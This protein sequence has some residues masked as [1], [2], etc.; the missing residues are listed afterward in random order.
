MATTRAIR[1][2]QTVATG[3]NISSSS[4]SQTSGEGVDFDS[5]RAL[6]LSNTAPK[7]EILSST[8]ADQTGLAANG[9][10]PAT[11]NSLRFKF[12]RLTQNAQTISGGV[13][14]SVT[15]PVFSFTSAIGGGTTQTQNNQ[16]GTAQTQGLNDHFITGSDAS[17][18]G[19]GTGRNDLQDMV[20]KFQ[21]NTSN[22]NSNGLHQATFSMQNH[23]PTLTAT[24]EKTWEGD[25]IVINASDSSHTLPPF[26]SA[27][28]FA[29]AGTK[30]IGI[31]A[32][33]LSSAFTVSE[34]SECFAFA[35]ASVTT[36]STLAVTPK[37]IYKPVVA[38]SSAFTLQATTFN[39]VPMDALTMAS[40][41]TVA[42]TPTLKV[43]VLGTNTI[44]Q[45]SASTVSA[46]AKAIFDISGDYRWSD[47][48][49]DT[50]LDR[51][52]LSDYAVAGYTLEDE[53]E[54]DDATLGDWDTWTFGTWAGDEGSWDTWKFSTWAIG[55]NFASEFTHSVVPLKKLFGAAALSSA[56]TIDDGAAFQLLGAS[57]MSS[58]FT[59][60]AT[61]TGTIDITQAMSSAFTLAVSDV[62]FLDNIL[63]LTLSSAFTLAVTDTLLFNQPVAISSAFTFGLSTVFVKYD[64]E[65]TA[66]SAFTTN[67][68]GQVKYGPEV[69][70][71]L[72]ALATTLFVGALRTQA[73]PYNIIT[74]D[75]ETR[76][77][78][79]PS[80]NRITA[81]MA[82]N[83]LNTI[84]NE[85]RLVG[86]MQE[87]RTH[88]L[89][90]P[91]IT[92]RFSTPR[93]RSE[94]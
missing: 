92:N 58:A 80:E 60:S 91:S 43:G 24:I 79:I 83:R 81:I 5:N 71:T 39:F 4:F 54:W 28:T 55:L 62:D 13:G 76:T 33:T 69:G 38:L 27:F 8:F 32:L 20:A 90:I 15:M 88:K 31:E 2:S 70:F 74:V 94:T 41:F 49:R 12:F 35:T 77:I 57:A 42:T 86:I 26:A 7:S 66:P 87:T 37:V 67:F 44:T 11:R 68:V 47:L 64:I 6:T 93:V 10:Y 61:A 84:S 22:N 75:S 9:I 45:A 73:D 53:Y 18:L 21:L 82:E 3:L 89:K 85:N 63:P 23:L 65:D 16:A 25:D 46:T 40:A 50:A 34:A 56:F 1:I 51:Y 29:G 17:V 48:L 19:V 72:N 52:V 30:I 36:A 78:V 59:V 14:M